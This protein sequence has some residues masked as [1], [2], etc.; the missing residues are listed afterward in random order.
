[1]N[2][3]TSHH[4]PPIIHIIHIYLNTKRTRDHKAD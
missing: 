4:H 1:M 2:K 3:L